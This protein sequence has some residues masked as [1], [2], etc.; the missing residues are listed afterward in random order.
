EGELS[1][2]EMQQL[3]LDTT[4]PMASVLVPYL[5]DIDELSPFYASA[6]EL[7]ADWDFTQPADSAPAA[8]FNAVWSHLLELTFH[9]D[10]RAGNWPT[11]GGRWFQVVT[12]L[13][14]QPAGPWWDDADTDVVERRDDIIR[15][16]M[17]DA[18]DD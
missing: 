13:L 17:I 18:R 8:Y 9:D 4:N 15:Q 16:A 3:Q 7:L 11:G 10:L 12:G 6:Q 5:L 14:E 1:V 2:S